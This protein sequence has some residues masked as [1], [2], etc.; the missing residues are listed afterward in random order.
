MG[1]QFDP[2]PLD[3]RGLK[4]MKATEPLLVIVVEQTL[5]EYTA[6]S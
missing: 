2:A 3:V 4:S 6:M 5:V 1:D